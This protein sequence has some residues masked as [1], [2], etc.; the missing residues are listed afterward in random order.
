MYHGNRASHL[1]EPLQDFIVR[2]CARV[3][4]TLID[5]EDSLVRLAE[6]SPEFHSW[7]ESRL[8]RV[9][10]RLEG[11]VASSL[12]KTLLRMGEEQKLDLLLGDLALRCD[13]DSRVRQI[14]VE[15]IAGPEIGD[16]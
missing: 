13:P 5:E 3:D 16:A 4:D 1:S 6:E 2:F 15:M 10:F 9:G 12:R 14:L 8:L 11:D 7:L